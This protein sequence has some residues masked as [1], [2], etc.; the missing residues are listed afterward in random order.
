MVASR[1]VGLCLERNVQ[2]GALVSVFDGILRVCG[3]PAGV[4]EVSVQGSGGRMR[5]KV[6][7]RDIPCC[8]WGYC[9]CV[10]GKAV[11]G[12][13]ERDYSWI[14]I[15]CEVVLLVSVRFCERLVVCSRLE[16]ASLQTV[17]S[18]TQM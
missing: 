18:N 6:Q 3:G 17:S 10:V 2:L 5:H 1:E 13:L 16:G 8:L 11:F 12:F 14:W 9:L 4:V 15:A 7:G